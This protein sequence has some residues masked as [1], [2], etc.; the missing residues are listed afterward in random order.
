MCLFRLNRLM[1]VG[2][3]RAVRTF[4]RFW[5]T[6]RYTEEYTMLADKYEKTVKPDELKELG[7]ALIDVYVVWCSV[8]VS[9][10]WYCVTVVPLWSSEVNVV[11]YVTV[12]VLYCRLWWYCGSPNSLPLLLWT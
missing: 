1:V 2:P 9:L 3:E 11:L 10:W 8:V 7:E 4:E 5:E 6:A 12:V